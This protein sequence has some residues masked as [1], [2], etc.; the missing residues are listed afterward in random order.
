MLQIITEG[1]S[2][3]SNAFKDIDGT[4][5]N[6]YIGNIGQYFVFANGR[7]ELLVGVNGTPPTKDDYTI[8]TTGLT[9]ISST[10]IPNSSSN[11]QTY[12]EN[13]HASY[14]STT[15]T[16]NTL[17]PIT[18]REVGL[19]CNVGSNSPYH[20]CLFAREVIEPVTIQPNETYTFTMR[21]E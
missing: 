20:R 10:T 5:Q 14:T 4:L 16:N 2:N 7:R 13:T 18:I 9:K 11:E 21:F 6:G 12:E 1:G 17:E 19:V 8:E 3:K 15:F